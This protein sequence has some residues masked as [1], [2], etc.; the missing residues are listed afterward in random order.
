MLRG[1]WHDADGLNDMRSVA[2]KKENA[3]DFCWRILNTRWFAL[4]GVE[5]RSYKFD[6]SSIIV[7]V[8]AQP[9]SAQPV[10]ARQWSHLNLTV[11]RVGRSVR[12]THLLCRNCNWN[13]Y[14][15]SAKPSVS[16]SAPWQNPRARSS[17]IMSR[18]RTS[19]SLVVVFVRVIFSRKFMKIR[20]KSTTWSS[21]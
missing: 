19:S 6:G 3:E 4:R 8:P 15:H 21:L 5:S 14:F 13:S 1:A 17:S 2:K 16:V 20:Y 7:A 10:P 12:S 9:S 18:R 11:V